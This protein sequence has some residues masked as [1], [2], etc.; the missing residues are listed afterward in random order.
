MKMSVWSLACRQSVFQ[1]YHRE[2]TFI[3]VLP[4]RWRRKPTGIEITSLSPYVLAI[5][6][7]MPVVQCLRDA[8]FDVQ[9]FN[10]VTS[11]WWL[12]ILTRY[13]ASLCE[14]CR[15]STR[16]FWG[17]CKNAPYEF[18]VIR[19]TRLDDNVSNWR[20]SVKMAAVHAR[21]K[22]QCRRWRWPNYAVFQTSII[23]RR[24]TRATRYLTRIVLHTDEDAQGDKLAKV[25]SRTSTT[26]G[27]LPT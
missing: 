4:T 16:R 9:I 17:F 18:T 20:V 26:A 7:H 19:P 11:Q 2:K 24:W 1:W 23:C 22:Y 8:A 5:N 21:R 13:S 10:G 14:R 27:I 15:Q 6:W 3:G 25:V 12:N